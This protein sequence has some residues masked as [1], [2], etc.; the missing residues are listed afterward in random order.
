MQHGGLAL[1]P[2][3]NFEGNTETEKYAKAFTNMIENAIAIKCISYNS[4]AGYIFTIEI[5]EQ[6]VVFYGL[7]DQNVFD[8]PVTKLLVKFVLISHEPTNYITNIGMKISKSGKK[9]K[10]T[11]TEEDF[12]KE[13]QIQL[14]IY[15]K[16]LKSNNIP[17]S[18]SIIYYDVIPSK[19]NSDILN[20]FYNKIIEKYKYTKNK[21]QES[22][23]NDVLKKNYGEMTLSKIVIDEIIRYKI[24]TKSN[25]DVGVIGMEYANDY[26]TF[27]NYLN[28][29]TGEAK[30][31]QLM[32]SSK[33]CGINC[34]CIANIIIN[35]I[36]LF[37]STGV[38]HMDLHVNNIM[39]NVDKQKSLLIDFGFYKKIVEDKEC[40]ERV[41]LTPNSII[42]KKVIKKG[43]VYGTTITKIMGID[44]I[45]KFLKLN[46]GKSYD[47]ITNEQGFMQSYLVGMSDEMRIKKIIKLFLLIVICD[48][49]LNNIRLEKP[50]IMM[51]DF[52]VFLGLQIATVSDGNADLFSS[53]NI[54]EID[55]ESISLDKWIYNNIN[56]NTRINYQLFFK[57]IFTAVLTKIKQMYLIND[58]NIIRIGTD[59]D[60]D[61]AVKH[62]YNK[63]T[64]GKQT[65]PPSGMLS[66]FNFGKE[67][68][69][70]PQSDI[71]SIFNFRKGG[72]QTKYK[73]KKN[74]KK[75]NHKRTKK[76]V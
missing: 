73:R 30:T 54:N 29:I 72:N 5:N 66:I 40:Q 69:Q 38:I 43:S 1:N 9:N 33:E 27:N 63:D 37:I 45:V 2:N 24:N 4:L 58:D 41:A 68:I 16:T 26:T 44:A 11:I 62:T 35:I 76:N 71:V 60:T 64:F 46:L 36:R 55:N 28:E 18:P 57:N 51:R 32:Y 23:Q 13:K 22:K 56:P 49:N 15:D 3:K 17:I 31:R 7:N 6:D 8:V 52:L 21:Y 42:Y 14:D 39:V 65:P 74:S 53:K 20:I 19:T 34:N 12:E 67:T 75:K 10:I 70:S 48:L 25:F 59:P 61:E 50:I 47:Y